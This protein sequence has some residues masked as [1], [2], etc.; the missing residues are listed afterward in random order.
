[1]DLS[2]LDILSPSEEGRKMHL[3]HPRTGDPWRD[4]A[5]NPLYITLLGQHSGAV[6]G[7]MEALQARLEARSPGAPI[8]T[9]E[10]RAADD[11][12]VLTAATRFWAFET[13]DGKPFPCTPE[14]AR[15]FWSDPRF[16][17][18]RHRALRFIADDGV[19]LAAPDTTSP[20]GPSATSS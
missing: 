20:P 15:R 16:A 9:R 4:S 12:E 6:Q 10:E 17:W 3:S 13:M 11:A 5:G 7:A 1:M 14:N 18:I 8:R 19:F 2:I